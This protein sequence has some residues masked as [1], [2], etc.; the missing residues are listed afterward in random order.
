[1]S[2][3]KNWIMVLFLFNEGFPSGLASCPDDWIHFQGSCYY[4]VN[5][6]T[7]WHGSSSY[8]QSQNSELVAVETE[9]ENDFLHRFI[10]RFRCSFNV[11]FWIDATD[12]ISDGVWV[13]ASSLTPLTYFN[14]GKNEPNGDINEDCI[15][16]DSGMWNDL[17]CDDRRYFV[18]EKKTLPIS[19]PSEGSSIIG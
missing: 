17:R 2:T 8:C 15:S 11:P 13:W 14:W 1:M 10:Q 9:V 4:F 16:V 5:N 7:T 19:C 6:F 18:C 3:P 12:M